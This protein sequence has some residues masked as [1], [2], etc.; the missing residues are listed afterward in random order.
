LIVVS[1]GYGV[2]GG[3]KSSPSVS[4]PSRNVIGDDPQYQFAAGSD[5][6]SDARHCDPR[7][8]VNKKRCCDEKKVAADDPCRDVKVVVIDAL[9]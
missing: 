8:V 2:V 3:W 5:A 9:K 4:P 1:V 6:E 7:T